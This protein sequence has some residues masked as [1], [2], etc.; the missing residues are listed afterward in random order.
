MFTTFTEP[1]SDHLQ[2]PEL[3]AVLGSVES[4]D[5]VARRIA[6]RVV[7]SA[8]CRSACAGCG[9]CRVRGRAGWVAVRWVDELPEVTRSHLGVFV[10]VP[11]RADQGAPGGAGGIG[12]LV[13]LLRFPRKPG[14][15]A[16]SRMPPITA[17]QPS[18]MP[19][20]WP[21][22]GWP[23][24]THARAEGEE[25]PHEVRAVLDGPAAQVRVPE[26]GAQP[27]LVGF[28]VEADA[29]DA[30]RDLIGEC[31]VVAGC[32]PDAADR[33]TDHLAHAE[34]AVGPDERRE[35][36]GECC[37][38]EAAAHVVEEHDRRAEA[39]D[40]EE[41][42]AP[43]VL[44]APLAQCRRRSADK[45][46]E[47]RVGQERG[48]RAG[49]WLLDEVQRGG[50]IDH[51]AHERQQHQ[52]HGVGAFGV[53]GEREVA[54]HVVEDERPGAPRSSSVGSSAT[55]GTVKPGVGA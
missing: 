49:A 54:E 1:S 4:D 37:G 47:R 52:G 19:S 48:A 46:V 11:P 17:A 21:P 45:G 5:A 39:Q 33:R 6:G 13:E 40:S 29:D 12:L 36:G 51:L 42:F 28:R 30:A 34:E 53:A 15:R 27:G 25:R 38:V 8:A 55:A 41:A 44:V 14:M 9:R 43:L 20:V 35:A 23:S 50:A 31:R 16:T 26:A 24:A 22:D 32:H 2:P 7:D 18:N 3:S 10:C